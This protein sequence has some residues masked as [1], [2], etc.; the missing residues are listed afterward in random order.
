MERT[1]E[2]VNDAISA[3]ESE[4]GGENPPAPQQQLVKMRD[5][6]RE[7]YI[8]IQKKELPEKNSRYSGLA[9][10]IVDEWP[11]NSKTGEKILRA[12]AAYKN[13]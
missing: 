9:R 5:E 3:L 7:I 10:V 12:I 2:L 6:L 1:L 13:L 8:Q 11:L 4:L